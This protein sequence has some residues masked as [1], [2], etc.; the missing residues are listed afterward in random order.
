MDVANQRLP[1]LEAVEQRDRTGAWPAH[2]YPGELQAWAVVYQTLF[3]RS[4]D[5]EAIVTVDGSTRRVTHH[6]VEALANEPLK[7]MYREVI[8]VGTLH[9]I[10]TAEGKRRF[11]VGNEDA[12]LVFELGAEPVELIDPFRWKRVRAHALWQVGSRRGRLQQPLELTEEPMGIQVVRELEAPNWV[13]ELLKQIE[14]YADL[15]AGWNGRNS[16]NC[17]DSKRHSSRWPER[18]PRLRDSRRCVAA[19]VCRVRALAMAWLFRCS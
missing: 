4:P 1:G 11:Q 17:R 8:L 13:V 6:S 5:A 7:P 19:Q 14:S 2:V 12:D 16:R 15:D 3:R 18:G 10:D 9:M